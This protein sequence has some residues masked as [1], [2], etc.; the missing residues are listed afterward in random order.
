[1][2]SA[3]GARVGE[4]VGDEGMESFTEEW[5]RGCPEMAVFWTASAGTAHA[6]GG[7]HEVEHSRQDRGY[8]SR[9]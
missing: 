2:V 4:R 5:N 6:K 9:S 7:H 8:V 3:A 1:M